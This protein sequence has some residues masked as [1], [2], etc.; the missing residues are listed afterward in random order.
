MLRAVLS[1]LLLAMTALPVATETNCD[2][3]YV[4]FLERLSSRD[5]VQGDRLANLHRKG[6]RVFDACDGGHL[7]NPEPMFRQL[8]RS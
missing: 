1:A 3:T 8:E 4:S 2:R 5:D 7:D 6:L